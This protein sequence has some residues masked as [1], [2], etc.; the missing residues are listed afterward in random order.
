MNEKAFLLDTD[1]TKT[2]V[3]PDNGKEFT[4]EEVYKLLEVDTVEALQP[5]DRDMILLVDEDGKRKGSPV[6]HQ[7]TWLLVDR[8]NPGEFILG[9]VLYCT[10]ELFS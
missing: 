8:L 5:L 2:K 10:R 3:V 1:G 9:K 4:L 6:N 7:A